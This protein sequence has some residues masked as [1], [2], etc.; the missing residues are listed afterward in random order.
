MEKSPNCP[1]A[2][3]SHPD[4]TPTSQSNLLFKCRVDVRL[5]ILTPS[6]LGRTEAPHHGVVKPESWCCRQSLLDRYSMSCGKRVE[7]TWQLLAQDATREK[8]GR[9]VGGASQLR[10][11][12]A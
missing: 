10:S 12:F 8:G 9:R 1:K 5:R 3:T 2:L 11:L 4:V 7:S 6:W